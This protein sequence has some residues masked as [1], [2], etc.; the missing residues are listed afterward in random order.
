MKTNGFIR[1]S[2]DELP[3]I[4]KKLRKQ[5][6]NEPIND[7]VEEEMAYRKSDFLDT[8]MK[9][10]LKEYTLR[11]KENGKWMKGMRRQPQRGK[12][13]K[14]DENARMRREMMKEAKEML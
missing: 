12:E 11:D 13:G 2:M 9:F 4:L 3:Q 7:I 5:I 14:M 6:Q 1:H 10:K 8:K